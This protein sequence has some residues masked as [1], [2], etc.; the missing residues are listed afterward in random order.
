LR[1]RLLAEL[2]ALATQDQATAWVRKAMAAKN[3][4]GATIAF[5]GLIFLNPTL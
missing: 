1:D 3:T 4:L 2:N 5:A